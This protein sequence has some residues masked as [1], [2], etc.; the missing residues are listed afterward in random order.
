MLDPDFPS[1]AV[2]RV[3]CQRSARFDATEA[4]SEDVALEV[5]LSLEGTMIINLPKTLA[6]KCPIPVLVG[7]L[8]AYLP[9]AVR[10]LFTPAPMPR[11]ATWLMTGIWPGLALLG[12]VWLRPRIWEAVVAIWR[13]WSAWNRGARQRFAGTLLLVGLGCTVSVFVTSGR[14]RT[15]ALASS[16]LLLLL[17]VVLAPITP[18]LISR[19]GRPAW[20]PPSSGRARS[21]ANIVLMA[22]ASA[23]FTLAYWVVGHVPLDAGGIA[24][25]CEQLV[26]D[27]AKLSAPSAALLLGTPTATAPLELIAL[28][29]PLRVFHKDESNYSV[30]I[31]ATQKNLTFPARAV[32]SVQDCER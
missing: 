17:L 9:W 3:M 22:P 28:S 13:S 25:R 18:P 2:S 31:P 8:L 27:A 7:S 16:I 6:T 11:D 12:V 10:A 4:R 14:L 15:I 30:W 19:K 23:L 1:A 21:V 32:Q 5:D 29:R 26:I 24:P 20:S